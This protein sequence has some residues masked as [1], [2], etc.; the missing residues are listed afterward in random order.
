MQDKL[1]DLRAELGM[2]TDYWAPVELK[3]EV[4]YP[5]VLDG[6][7]D[8]LR[9]I[10]D[11]IQE[12]CFPS[13][14]PDMSIRN[15]DEQRPQ[16]AH[17]ELLAPIISRT[18]GTLLFPNGTEDR[19]GRLTEAQQRSVYFQNACRIFGQTGDYSELVR[20]G[21]FPADADKDDEDET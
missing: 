1:G 14:T 10:A 8:S 16:S 3:R 7:V 21:I 12:A 4:E 13:S 20:L 18:D 6:V 17:G 11:V 9:H 19:H 5:E 2:P 15:E